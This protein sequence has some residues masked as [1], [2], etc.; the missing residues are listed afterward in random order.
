[1][2]EEKPRAGPVFSV[3]GLLFVLTGILID[4]F[5]KRKEE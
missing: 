5:R 2:V 3:I 1:M 4:V